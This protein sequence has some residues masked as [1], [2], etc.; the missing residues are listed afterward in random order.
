MSA[1]KILALLDHP[2][3]V[4][5]YQAWLEAGSSDAGLVHQ[6]SNAS[7]TSAV[8][9]LSSTTQAWTQDEV[10]EPLP[11]VKILRHVRVRYAVDGPAE[12]R[13]HTKRNRETGQLRFGTAH[14]DAVL[15]VSDVAGLL[16]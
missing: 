3:I 9:L 14:P 7:L 10:E 16:G 5:Y 15:L 4:R 8:Q 13:Q 1:R 12:T 11:N 6:S 2:H